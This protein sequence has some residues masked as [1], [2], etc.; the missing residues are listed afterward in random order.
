MSEGKGDRIEEL[1]GLYGPV[2]LEEKQVQRIWAR[3]SFRREGMVTR[4]GRRLE[5]LDP[6]RWN[7]QEGPDFKEAVLELDGRRLHGDVEIHLHEKDWKRHGHGADPNFDGVVLHVILFPERRADGSIPSK[8]R[9]ETLEWLK[10]LDQD[11]ETYFE[12]Q[13]ADQLLDEGLP[14]PLA[15][16]LN[17]PLEARET[18][19]WNASLQRWQR[20]REIARKRIEYF[21]WRAACHQQMLEV[22]GLRRNR[23]TMSRLASEYPLEMWEKD[24]ASVAQR[25]FEGA[26]GD[27][28]LAGCRPANHPKRRLESYA[29]WIPQRRADWPKTLLSG[30]PHLSGLPSGIP[31]RIPRIGPKRK[32]CNISKIEEDWR[33]F[34]SPAVGGTRFHT[35]VVDGLWPLVSEQKG[36]DRFLPWFIWPVG[37]IPDR[38][39][40]ALQTLELVGPGRP[41]CN[42]WTQGVLRLLEPDYDSESSPGAGKG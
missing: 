36:E 29:E 3:R 23:A 32:E 28:N 11:L 10:Y 24:P 27:W 17:L 33:R 7:F 26:K 31:T 8:S 41:L 2:F 40:K 16:L 39:K 25:A 19:L 37:D 18:V 4:S 15:A 12:D 38:M 34:F 30:G 42:G 14:Q 22:L 35:W 9:F 1:T 5:V 20:K 13:G 6:G 21:G